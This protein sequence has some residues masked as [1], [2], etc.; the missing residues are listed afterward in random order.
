MENS[1]WHDNNKDRK[2]LIVLKVRWRLASSRHI[3]DSAG[4]KGWNIPMTVFDYEVLTVGLVYLPFAFDDIC[5]V[6]YSI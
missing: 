6:I 4:N 2:K 5:P 3:E 1:Q